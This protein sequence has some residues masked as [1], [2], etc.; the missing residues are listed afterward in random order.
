MADLP[1]PRTSWQR[2]ITSAALS[3]LAGNEDDV[4]RAGILKRGA[5]L[6]SA[7][8]DQILGEAYTAVQRGSRATVSLKSGT[9]ADDSPLADSLR[10][11]KRAVVII[12]IID[13]NGIVR[14]RQVTIPIDD[15]TTAGDVRGQIQ[16]AIDQWN[17]KY[18][19]R[20]DEESW[21]IS[22]IL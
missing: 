1:E 8:V 2:R 9:M 6:D 7:S 21:T 16:D 22:Y 13:E 15:D 3:I 20:I 10:L 14:H 17:A 4:V 5:F 19:L 12:P 18:K 11:G